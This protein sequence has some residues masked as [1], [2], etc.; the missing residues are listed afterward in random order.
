MPI[1]LGQFGHPSIG[2]CDAGVPGIWTLE[3]IPCWN[4]HTST[5]EYIVS[6]ES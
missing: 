2:T 1:G 6:S 3:N 5:T 4:F